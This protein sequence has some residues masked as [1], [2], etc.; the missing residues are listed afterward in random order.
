MRG[1]GRPFPHLPTGK[2]PGQY[3]GLT[4]NRKS[5]ALR[6][7]LM[8]QD[9]RRPKSGHSHPEPG[10]RGH[11]PRDRGDGDRRSRGGDRPAKAQVLKHRG[12][13]PR[14]VHGIGQARRGQV[15]RRV[16][17]HERQATL[18]KG[19]P[20]AGRPPRWWRRPGPAAPTEP[21]LRRGLA[22]FNHLARA[23]AGSPRRMGSETLSVE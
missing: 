14:V 23:G 20:P 4:R 13:R 9:V 10:T 11:T 8:K 7:H 1:H 21:R 18:G 17:D 19:T 22:W 6:G 5:S 16:A 15:V 3:F 2:H 12:H